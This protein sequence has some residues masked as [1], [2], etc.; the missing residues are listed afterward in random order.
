MPH[1]AFVF[2]S[3]STTYDSCI[4]DKKTQLKK[5]KEK[6][7][8]FSAS[9]FVV[10]KN[11]N[12]ILIVTAEHVCTAPSWAKRKSMNGTTF[13]GDKFKLKLINKNARHDICLLKTEIND[14]T[15]IKVVPIAKKKIKIGEKVYNMAAPDGVFNPGMVPM[16]EGRYS[17]MKYEE[18]IY[19]I[20]ATFG[21]SGSP[22]LNEN[23]EAIGLLS[24]VYVRFPFIS[25][26][27]NQP[28]FRK[29]LIN[30]IERYKFSMHPKVFYRF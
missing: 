12:T 16:L 1:E 26:S 7:R 30:E 15:I 19:T 5:C 28:F 4:K 23:K 18:Y 6:T 14:T 17:G 24:K 22:I 8:S 2:I 10:W 29:W 27:P 9:G 11:D 3:G 25:V 21:S 20:P 13:Y